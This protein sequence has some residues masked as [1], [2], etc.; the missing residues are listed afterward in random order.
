MI[1]ELNLDTVDSCG[2]SDKVRISNLYQGGTRWCVRRAVNSCFGDAGSIPA[3]GAQSLNYVRRI[4][5][6]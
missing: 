1:S 5:R 4:T 6:A 3:P 2:Y